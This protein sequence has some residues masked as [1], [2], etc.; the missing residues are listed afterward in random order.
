MAFLLPYLATAAATYGGHK[1]A[2]MGEHLIDRIQAH[3]MI[4]E[5]AWKKWMFIIMGKKNC[6]GI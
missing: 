3:I 6:S 4:L 5:A 2:T 1:L